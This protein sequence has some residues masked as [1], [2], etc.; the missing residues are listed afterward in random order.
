MSET[1]TF[2]RLFKCGRVRD[3]MFRMKSKKAVK[4]MVALILGILIMV[5]LYKRLVPQSYTSKH[6]QRMQTYVIST[7]SGNVSSQLGSGKVKPTKDDQFKERN[8]SVHVFQ[9]KVHGSA[10]ESNQSTLIP[11]K[12]PSYSQNTSIS[13]RR[14]LFPIHFCEGGP[15]WNFLSFR[16]LVAYAITHN[17]SI[18]TIPFRNHH[19]NNFTKLWRSFEETLDISQLRKIVDVVTPEV[20]KAECGSNISTFVQYPI[21]Q[22]REIS[23]K[24][25]RGQYKQTRK[26]V[27]E[28]WGIDLPDTSHKN[29][30]VTETEQQMLNADDNRCLAI[31]GPRQIPH[32]LTEKEFG[33]LNLV[34]SHLL[35]AKHIRKMS[36]YVISALCGG[37]PYIALHWRN[38]TGEMIEFHSIYCNPMEVCIRNLEMLSN[39][40]QIIAESVGQLMKDRGIDC[41]YVS[42]PPRKQEF[43][44]RLRNVVPRVHTANFIK[45]LNSEELRSL[46]NDEYILSLVEQEVCEGAE[47]FLRCAVSSWSEFVRIR[48]D[49]IGK[50]VGYLRDLPGV[51]K[52]IFT[53]I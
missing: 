15:N 21:S 28:L 22:L 41:V 1:I 30:T 32:F 29:R 6:A 53:L 20:Y 33:V 11:D 3:L 26:L 9:N 35:K 2:E 13:D 8:E 18:V 42:V 25:N 43:V 50:E 46:E 12:P 36:A 48:R 39:A 52:E 17:R 10:V 51:P 16:M 49:N 27:K 40:S 34:D 4:R 38:R 44:E 24:E 47:V 5:F 23:K 31:H 7:I 19:L 45:S 37:K 14:Y